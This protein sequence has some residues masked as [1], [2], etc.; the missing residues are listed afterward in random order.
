ML[1]NC[2]CELRIWL[3]GGNSS[4]KTYHQVYS[5]HVVPRTGSLADATA[6]TADSNEVTTLEMQSQAEHRM[7]ASRCRSWS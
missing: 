3:Y 6:R 4:A 1:G 7:S 2:N 5:D